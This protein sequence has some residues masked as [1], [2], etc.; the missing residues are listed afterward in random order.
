MAEN[1]DVT[2]FK[3]GIVTEYGAKAMKLPKHSVVFYV[4]NG[5]KPLIDVSTG[6]T[7]SYNG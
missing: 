2:K 7:F 1:M 5:I 4:D 3:W 6:N